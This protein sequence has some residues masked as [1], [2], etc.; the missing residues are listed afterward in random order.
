MNPR[1]RARAAIAA[2]AAITLTYGYNVQRNREGQAQLH[3]ACTSIRLSIDERMKGDSLAML[4]EDP[5]AV[6]RDLRAE[7][8]AP[9]VTIEP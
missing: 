1:T 7:L 4:L 8:D 9:C 2:V 5:A 3:A 6:T